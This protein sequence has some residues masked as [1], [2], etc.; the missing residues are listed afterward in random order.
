MAEEGI[1]ELVPLD[2]IK[3]LEREIEEL[4][5]AIYTKPET[6]I[7]KSSEFSLLV[8]LIKSNQEIINT[9]VRSNLELQSRISEAV[10]AINEL[11]R[12]IKKLIDILKEAAVETAVGGEETTEE[13]K[14][15]EDITKTLEIVVNK[16]YEKFDLIEKQNN[17]I[18]ELLN[19]IS[20]SLKEKKE[21]KK[22]TPARKPLPPLPPPP[23]PPP[24][25]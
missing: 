14:E 8:D 25:R 12:E 1:Y 23:G 17:K 4:K 13:K 9:I 22:P 15:K 6:K 24:I 10:V 7:E 19:D 5:K 16:L 21:E 18:I 11:T 3:K 20:K 2:P